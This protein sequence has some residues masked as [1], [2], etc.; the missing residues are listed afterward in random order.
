MMAKKEP[1]PRQASRANIDRAIGPLLEKIWKLGISTFQSCSGHMKAE[2]FPSALIWLDNDAISD[3]QIV[4]ISEIEG[5]EQVSRMWGRERSP[6]VEIIFEGETLPRYKKICK[7]IYCI[8]S[9]PKPD[10]PP[11]EYQSEGGY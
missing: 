5:V 2:G 1:L 3:E 9:E 6:V 8:L 10:F 11:L 7:E 4:A